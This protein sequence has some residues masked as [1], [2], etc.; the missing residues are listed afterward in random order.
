LQLAVDEGA[1]GQAAEQREGGADE[2]VMVWESD[3]AVKQCFMA[4]AMA[5][6]W[7]RISLS[8]A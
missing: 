1:A 5:L 3:K 7:A 6:P 2:H 4:Y 8:A